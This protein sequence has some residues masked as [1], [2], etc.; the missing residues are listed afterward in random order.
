MTALPA[1][2]NY[3]HVQLAEALNSEL[4]QRLGRR[5]S[6]TPAY[7][8]R[9][10]Y[11]PKH[12]DV[13]AHLPL[14][15]VSENYAE[16]VKGE[17]VGGSR[18]KLNLSMMK[19]PN[20]D[21]TDGE[22]RYLVNLNCGSDAAEDEVTVERR[23][24]THNGPMVS[25]H[26]PRQGNG[27]FR[28][29]SLDPT[30][31]MQLVVANSFPIPDRKIHA[32]APPVRHP[33]FTISHTSQDEDDATGLTPSNLEWQTRPTE[34]GPLR[35]TLVDTAEGDAAAEAG[36]PLIHAIYHHIG[37]GFALPRDYSEGVLLLSENL[38]DEAEA[39]A[40]A[41]LLGLLRQVRSINQPPPRPRKK[42]FVQR[43]L[44]KI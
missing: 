32:A 16:A 6:P 39:L 2:G 28:V 30:Q 35:Y 5:L 26:L 19:R 33:W 18:Y 12:K 22:V 38:D 20:G 23:V 29:A 27:S 17:F 42:L 44:G 9:V 15:D 41:T 3:H 1:Y 10:V 24:P 14:Y 36:E 7:L 37:V 31:N 8:S 13:T 11:V 40:V 4:D 21:G 43:V 25:M 34:H